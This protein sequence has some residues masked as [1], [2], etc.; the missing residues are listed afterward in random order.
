MLVLSISPVYAYDTTT[1]RIDIP[2]N[3]KKSENFINKVLNIKKYGFCQL[4]YICN[5]YKMGFVDFDYSLYDYVCN[6]EIHFFAL[7]KIIGR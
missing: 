3:F 6:N 1:Y 7:C 2:N 5:D 4:I